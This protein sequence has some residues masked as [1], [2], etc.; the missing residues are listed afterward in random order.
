MIRPLR[1]SGAGQ[2][3]GID[4]WTEAMTGK[5]AEEFFF[6]A[7]SMSD[8]NLVLQHGLESRPE[9]A[10]FWGVDEILHSDAVNVLRRPSDGLIGV[11]VRDK[12]IG[13]SALELPRSHAN[14]N[15][16]IRAATGDTGRLEVDRSEGQ[17]LD[18]CAKIHQARMLR[19][20][21]KKSILT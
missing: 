18:G 2:K 12:Q 1:P 8:D 5:G 4:P 14:L 10:Q 21:G 15:R 17:F 6:R 16:H 11:Q 7:L 13:K 3:Q 19:Q 9:R 20:C